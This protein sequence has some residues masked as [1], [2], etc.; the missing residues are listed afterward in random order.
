MSTLSLTQNSESFWKFAGPAAAI[1]ILAIGFSSIGQP[2]NLP[3]M[4]DL[5][6][7]QEIQ[8]AKAK[9]EMAKQYQALLRGLNATNLNPSSIE[10]P[11]LEQATIANLGLQ[12]QQA[13]AKQIQDPS[14]PNFRQTFDGAIIRAILTNAR[15]M[16]L[17]SGID[18]PTIS[19]DGDPGIVVSYWSAKEQKQISLRMPP[20]MLS[21]IA[22]AYT[23]ALVTQHQ[24]RT[25]TEFPTAVDT[26]KLIL[27]LE[28]YADKSIEKSAYE[29]KDRM[30]GQ[31]QELNAQLSQE[32][33]EKEAVYHVDINGGIYTEDN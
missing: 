6:T 26:Q 11:G 29:G 25:A 17:E 23:E 13:M 1:T 5:P 16:L 22:Q 21:V 12:L 9:D 4:A 2:T 8:I 27:G 30:V 19:K 28:K 15:K 3:N 31:I 10:N 33:Q 20:A 18:Q 32:K 14:H 7:E 24:I